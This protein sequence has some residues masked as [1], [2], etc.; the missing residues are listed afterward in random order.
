MSVVVET[1]SASLIK[2]DDLSSFPYSSGV[3]AWTAVMLGASAFSEVM[4]TAWDTS[5]G[6][7]T[8]NS[9]EILDAI[10]ARPDDDPAS[11]IEQNLCDFT[12][13]RKQLKELDETAHELCVPAW[14]NS[15]T[16]SRHLEK[17]IFR[18]SHRVTQP[19]SAG[20]TEI[21]TGA[22][23]QRILETDDIPFLYSRITRYRLMER[24]PPVGSSRLGASLLDANGAQVSTEQVNL[25]GMV[26]MSISITIQRTDY[27]Q[28]CR[29]LPLTAFGSL[30]AHNVSPI[31]NGRS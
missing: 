25:G 14:A 18:S 12:H 9:W 1:Q 3:H 29:L 15:N 24:S 27:H 10:R 4:R 31:H 16:S 22:L 8:L 5:I 19:T 30:P 21:N 23:F 11:I 20:S 26:V 28:G 7:D 17:R 13:A 6:S 2:R